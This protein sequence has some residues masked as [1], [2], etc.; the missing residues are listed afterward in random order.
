MTIE[1]ACLPDVEAWFP[2]GLP[3]NAGGDHGGEEAE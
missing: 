2:T 1:T 3:S